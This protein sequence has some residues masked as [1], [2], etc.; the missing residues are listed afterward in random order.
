MLP[1][2]DD[3]YIIDVKYFWKKIYDNS[4]HKSIIV[5]ISRNNLDNNLENYLDELK[6]LNDYLYNEGYEFY[7]EEN[8]ADSYISV[9]TGLIILNNINDIDNYKNI[10]SI[11][12]HYKYQ[13]IINQ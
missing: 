6:M 13:K 5:Y 8:S 9:D 4:Y 10:N 7:T 11:R 3:N 2:N 1:L 12:I